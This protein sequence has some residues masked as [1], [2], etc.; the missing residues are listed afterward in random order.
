MASFKVTKFEWVTNQLRLIKAHL[1]D[2]PKTHQ[3]QVTISLDDEEVK[4][5][6]HA[7]QAIGITP[8][9]FLQMCARLGFEDEVEPYR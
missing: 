1:D 8:E 7:A 2:P 5:M 4:Q 3:F 9:K 6:R